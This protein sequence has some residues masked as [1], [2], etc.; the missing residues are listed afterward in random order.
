MSAAVR[1]PYTARAYTQNGPYTA[2]NGPHTAQNGSYTARAAREGPHHT[3]RNPAYTAAAAQTYTPRQSSPQYTRRTQVPMTPRTRP[4]PKARSARLYTRAATTPRQVT[5]VDH[6]IKRGWARPSYNDRN[7]ACYDGRLE[8]VHLL[9]QTS[10]YG[11]SRMIPPPTGKLD[12]G[13]IWKDPLPPAGVKSLDE[14]EITS[15]YNLHRFFRTF[16][17]RNYF[18]GQPIQ[19]ARPYELNDVE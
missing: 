11:F 1:Q 16:P 19:L 10:Q 2:H 13:P 5:E 7:T 14:K 9:G 17:I 8:Y 3:Y 15:P 6:D 18:P 12:Y 4:P